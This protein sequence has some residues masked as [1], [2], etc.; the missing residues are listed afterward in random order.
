MA[1]FTDEERKELIFKIAD[2]IITNNSS[3]RKT[4]EIFG[5]SNFSVSDYMNDKLML[6]D[7]EKYKKVQEILNGNKPKTIEDESV[8][9][10]ILE[11][12]KLI[13]SGMTATEVANSFGISID[14][15]HDD[16]TSRLPKI[17]KELAVCIS[18]KLKLNSTNNL[19]H[20]K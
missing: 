7:V 11:E 4:A 5:I 12:T 17:D 14:V 9:T 20:K 15:I 10:R 16:L 6:L 8:K 2:Y 3:T 1:R 18:E 19:Q 13:N